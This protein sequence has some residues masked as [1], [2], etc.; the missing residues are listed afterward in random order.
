M[1]AWQCPKCPYMNHGGICTKC[2]FMP[3]TDEVP[4]RVLLCA[5]GYNLRVVEDAVLFSAEVGIAGCF[6]RLTF[7]RHAGCWYVSIID[8]KDRAMV[9]HITDAMELIEQWFGGDHYSPHGEYKP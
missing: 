8:S 2:G 4:N 7:T 1:A 3:S 9:G 6:T 5:I